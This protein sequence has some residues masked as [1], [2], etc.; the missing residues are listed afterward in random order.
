MN[1]FESPKRVVLRLPRY[2]QVLL[3][4]VTAFVGVTLFPPML[5]ASGS[6]S[7]THHYRGW[8]E[9]IG[10]MGAKDLID[11]PRLVLLWAVVVAVTAVLIFLT[12]ERDK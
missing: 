6:F 3:G 2:K 5:V 8:F 11:W 1:L 9:F 7:T 4:G 10:G 12:Y